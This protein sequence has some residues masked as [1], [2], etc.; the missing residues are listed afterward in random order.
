MSVDPTPCFEPERL[1]EMV[2]RGFADTRERARFLAHFTLACPTC[3][4]S[5]FQWAERPDPPEPENKPTPKAPGPLFDPPRRALLRQ[6]ADVRGAFGPGV[7][8]MGEPLHFL[9]SLLEESRHASLGLPEPEAVACVR[10]GLEDVHLLR[11]FLRQEAPGSSGDLT[12][13]SISELMALQG[14]AY[15]ALAAELQRHG[16][17]QEAG[18]FRQ[19]AER[20]RLQLEMTRWL[21]AI[22]HPEESRE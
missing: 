12:D 13:R 19:R 11:Q 3:R 18:S 6:R 14:W 16:R 4:E 9:R 15:E 22:A 21:E 10:R 17:R 7:R 5:F 1:Q 2:A 20:T 8:A